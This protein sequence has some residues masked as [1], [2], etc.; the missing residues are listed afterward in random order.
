MAT[1]GR[2]LDY[3]LS[4][5]HHHLRVA[6]PSLFP[7][8]SIS[9]DHRRSEPTTTLH[10]PSFSATPSL[11]PPLAR[12]SS[13]DHPPPP[14]RPAPATPRLTF[15]LVLP[16]RFP[17]FLSSSRFLPSP[18]RRELLLVSRTRGSPFLSQISP[19]PSASLRVFRR[20][21]SPLYQPR[22]LSASLSLR[23]EIA[24]PR[25]SSVLLPSRCNLRWGGT[26]T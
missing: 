14:S 11:S 20:S 15:L 2:S 8:P 17:R 12:A 23:R 1:A 16:S 22:F 25:S 24:P 21:Y 5:F 9:L 7:P 26:G 4:L 13:S 19:F 10:S 18:P 6:S 3:A